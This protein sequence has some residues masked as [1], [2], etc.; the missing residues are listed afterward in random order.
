MEANP[1]AMNSMIGRQRLAARIVRRSPMMLN[2][3]TFMTM[4]VEITISK[5]PVQQSTQEPVLA[6]QQLILVENH[7]PRAW[8]LIS[9]PMNIP[10]RYVFCGLSCVN[11]NIGIHSMIGEVGGV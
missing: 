10:Q 5:S 11:H 1:L 8:V 7:D 3:P 9:D 2:L 6:H 4:A